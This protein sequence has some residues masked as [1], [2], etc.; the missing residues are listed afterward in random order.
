MAAGLPLKLNV[1]C[2]GVDAAGK[3]FQEHTYTTAV[4]ER[5]GRLLT[6]HQLK[7]G[8]R[9]QLHLLSRPDQEA[10]VETVQALGTGNE[11]TEWGFQFLTLLE[12]FWG[13]RFPTG[14][15][16][17]AATESFDATTAR[18][19]E[20][21]E[22][23]MFR[24]H[25]DEH[26]RHCTQEIDTLRERFS[27]E[28]QSAL[29][30]AARQLQQ[31]ALSTMQITFRSL[32]EDLAHQAEEIVDKNLKRLREET[33][34]TGVQHAK[35]LDEEAEKKVQRFQERLEQLQA[36]GELAL[37]QAVE[38]AQANFHTGCSGLLRDLLHSAETAK[39]SRPPTA[40]RK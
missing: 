13:L 40:R 15:A 6:Q 38:T 4:E 23:V 8:S 10:E 28:L 11:G 34:Q 20:T 18:A 29:D 39:P 33:D 7:Q 17:R 37:Q 25:A 35:Y 1:L 30:S 26:L 32:L 9:L 3:P 22:L 21:E 5:G 19:G 24:A 31:L 2:S 27:R 36:E 16:A 12:N 14:K